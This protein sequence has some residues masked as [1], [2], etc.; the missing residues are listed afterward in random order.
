MYEFSA[1]MPYEIENIDKLLNINNQIEKS[2]ITSLFFS[3]PST[4]ELFTG[5]EQYRNGDFNKK[6]S[7]W[8]S[9]I[10]YCLGSG[11]NF[12]YLLNNPSRLKIENIDF[13]KQLEKLDFLL[14]ELQK[15]GVKNLRIAE[16][17]LMSYIEKHYHYFNIYASTSF[18]FKS[19]QEYQNFIFMHPNVKQVVPS[20]DT[21]KNFV[22][23]HNLKKILPNMEIEIM[24]N[25]GCIQGCPNRDGHASEIMDRHIIYKNDNALSNF[26]YSTF[27][28]GE[29]EHNNPFFTIAK[30]NI[31]YPWEIEEYS[32]IGINHFKLVGR[33][34]FSYSQE[35]YLNEYLL[36]LKGIDNINNIKNE[37][38]NT[39]VHHLS[40]NPVLKQLSVK[41]LKNYLPNINYFKKHGELC[42]VNCGVK[43][44]YCYKCAE[45][46]KKV[47]EKKQ[48]E[49][50]KRNVPFCYFN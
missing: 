14:I 46:I 44:Q 29:I 26:Y 24:V 48:E 22:F 17:K 30:A 35:I 37:P 40:N 28:C 16:H 38:I 43:C 5:F 20:H 25:E 8:Q 41:E 18:E 31:I 50:K 34:A 7:Y 45:K 6:W 13:E 11:Q 49:Q 39:F 47:F 36:Y 27:F 21:V 12:I 3:L 42:A 23:L 32:K 9:L 4:C 33:D 1:P 10:S 15:L 19:L 2:R